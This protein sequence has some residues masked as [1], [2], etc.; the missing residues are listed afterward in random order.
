M[1]SFAV[2]VAAVRPKTLSLSLIPV[3]VGTALAYADTGNIAWWA[4]C[5]AML[6][7]VF[8]QIGTNLHNDVA[9]FE[10]GTDTVDR[11][12]PLRATAQGWINPNTVRRASMLSFV[13]AFVLGIYLVVVGGWPILVLGLVSMAAGVA[14][15]AGPFPISSYPFGELFVFLFFGLAAVGGAYYL[16]T[17]ALSQ[18]AILAGSALGLLAAAVLVVNNYRDSETDASSGRR[19][20]AVLAGAVWSKFEYALLVLLPFGLLL[21]MNLPENKGHHVL[22]P[23]LTL[24]WALYLIYRIYHLP[25]SRQLNGLLAQTAQLQLGF[26]GLLVLGAV[27]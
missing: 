14:Y 9:D 6:A 25:R 20:L 26:G 15:S 10:L 27:L 18:E 21:L 23:W 12:G 2:W 22:L 4:V 11:L 19:T 8:I 3:L 1:S 5:G 24:P 7:A 17:L 16:Q 13:C